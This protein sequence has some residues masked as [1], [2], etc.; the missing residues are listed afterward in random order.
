M[1]GASDLDH[2]GPLRQMEGFQRA[3][4]LFDPAPCTAGVRRITGTPMPKDEPTRPAPFGACLDY[5][6]ARGSS[7][8]RL[9]SDAA[10]QLVR[11]YRADT[12]RGGSVAHAYGARGVPAAH[13]ESTGMHRSSAAHTRRPRSRAEEWGARR[14]PGDADGDGSPQSKLTVAPDP[15]VK[16]EPA[17]YRQEFELAERRGLSAQILARQAWRL[18]A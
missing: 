1:A 6:L 12:G 18:P 17:A 3:A 4:W 5:V 14:I 8:S 10:G 13:L 15:R 9:E 2:V 7:A 11:R 16:L